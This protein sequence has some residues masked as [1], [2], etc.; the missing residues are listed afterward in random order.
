[1][2]NTLRNILAAGCH[3]DKVKEEREAEKLE[4]RI[5]PARIDTVRDTIEVEN[6]S[7][8]LNMIGR[9][10]DIYSEEVGLKGDL[11]FELSPN[12]DYYVLTKKR[13]WQNEVRGERVQIYDEVYFY[14][15]LKEPRKLKGFGSSAVY[16]KDWT[17]TNIFLDRE[18]A[19]NSEDFKRAEEIYLECLDA[20]ETPTINGRMRVAP[21]EDGG[22]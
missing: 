9:K 19:G 10:M 17:M 2:K 6:Y 3:G 22:I 14:A 1:M 21:I 20:L 11:E 13:F 7:H 12:G 15:S 5:T 8:Y 16:D 4:A 18:T